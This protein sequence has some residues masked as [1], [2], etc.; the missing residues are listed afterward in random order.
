MR[1]QVFLKNPM[2]G[3]L[4]MTITMMM[5]GASGVGK[6]T[7]L[8]TMYRALLRMDTE[9]QA[10]FTFKAIGDTIHDL[11]DAYEKLEDLIKIP[12]NTELSERLLPA[13]QGI[14]ERNFSVLFKGK[15]EFDFRFFDHAGGLIKMKEK[16]NPADVTLFKSL[17]QEAIVIINVIDGAVLVQGSE[18]LNNRINNPYL[19]YELLSE[20]LNDD[21][22][23]L[24]LF[25]ITKCEAFLKNSNGRK[26]LH[27]K[28]EERHKEV[29]NLIRDSHRK[30]VVGVL[31]PVK[32]LGCVEFS[33]IKNFGEKEKEKL[34]FVRKPSLQFKPENI[35][36][37]LRYALAFALSQHDKNRGLF[38]NFF[39]WLLNKDEVFQN[40]L[41]QFANNRD[42]TFKMYGSTS[43]LP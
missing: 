39:R 9:A 6:T 37:P 10:G 16:D 40:A 30:N 29:L 43:L 22:E 1:Q 3:E 17:L 7:M 34:I 42:K 8:A 11:N 14:L 35:E 15:K 20:A 31:I 19:I 23:H 28:F 24:V 32:T 2:K 26:L 21:Q 12:G 33:H 4:P 25:V 36:Q 5:L 18:F 27:D 38:E 13:D 41:K